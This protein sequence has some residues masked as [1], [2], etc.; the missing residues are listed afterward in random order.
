MAH[1]YHDSETGEQG[2]AGKPSKEERAAGKEEEEELDPH[3]VQQMDD[4]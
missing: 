1:F 3:E 4:E 2:Y